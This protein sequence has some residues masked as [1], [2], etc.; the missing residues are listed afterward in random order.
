LQTVYGLPREQ[1]AELHQ[2][3]SM[4]GRTAGD[5]APAP[6]PLELFGS[7]FREAPTAVVTTEA[8]PDDIKAITAQVARARAEADLVLVTIHA[9]ENGPSREEPAAFLQP[10][11][12]ACIDAGAD[13]FLG[14]GPHVLRGI[15]L[16]KGRPIFYSLGNFFFEA[17]TIEQIPEEIYE[18]CGIGSLSPSNFFHKVM[19]RMFEQDVFWEGIVPR[20]CF[21]NG[22]LTEAILYPVDLGRHDRGTQRGTP[23]LARGAVAARILQRQAALAR[24]FGTHVEVATDGIGRIELSRS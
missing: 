17:E 20:L 1:I 2:I 13:L 21:E 6:T 15:E 14:H 24:E 12:R 4:L 3:G 7:T 23:A 8:D 18:N 19:D 10:F 11:A 16:Y 5:V 9:H 22:R